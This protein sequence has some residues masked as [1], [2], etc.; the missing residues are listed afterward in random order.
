MPTQKEVKKMRI[1]PIPKKI[2]QLPGIFTLGGELTINLGEF[3]PNLIK[4]INRDLKLKNVIPVNTSATIE[5]KKMKLEDEAYKIKVSQDKIEI[6]ASSDQGIFYAIKTL[7]QAKNKNKLECFEID[8]SPDLKIRGAMI[9]ISRSKVPTLKTLKE[10]VDILSDLKYNHLELYVEGFSYEYKSFPEVL[11]ERNYIKLE[12]YIELEQYANERYIDLVP[13]QNG[14]GHMADWLSRKEYNKLAECEQG[15]HIWGCHRPPSTIDP[16]NKNSYKLVKKMYED[17]LPYFKSKYFNMNFD[18]PYELGY[19]KSKEK[20]EATSKEDVF[21]EYLTSLVKVVR[22][23]DKTPLIW[24]DCIVHHENAVEKLPKDVIVIDWGYHKDYDFDKHAELLSKKKRKFMVAPGTV[25]WSTLAGRYQD[26][27]STIKNSSEA[28]K[29]YN[30]L[31]LLVTDWGDIGHLQY[32]P[33]S[34][35]GFIN[36]AMCAW[37]ICD[38]NLIQEYLSDLVGS[39]C[40]EV[41]M[42]LSKYTELEGPYRDYGSRLFSSILWAEHSMRQEDIIDFFL[43]KMKSNLIE[44]KKLKELDK[45]FRLSLMKIKDED[46]LVKAE[47]E[48][49]INLLLTLVDVQYNLKKVIDNNEK[50]VFDKDILILESY[51]KRHI[52][53]WKLRNIEPGIIPSGNRIKWLMKILKEIDERS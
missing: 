17:M 36:A 46:S 41:I 23:Y 37:S 3:S 42:E 33:F 35:P 20:C 51:L 9:D 6:Y 7:K 40:S 39:T 5:L 19:G 26:M 48:N 27:M 31:G 53:L 25:T 28:V 30:G 12:E 50:N 44:D 2:N 14:F 15:F 10:M 11:I 1:I 16:T 47:I 4:F 32:L 34:Y 49:T 22:K 13:N 52:E 45:L 8:D 24:G 21:I 38:E 29:K 43:S 18:E